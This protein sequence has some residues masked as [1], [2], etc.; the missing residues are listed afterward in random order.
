M[1][2]QHEP[3]AIHLDQQIVLLQTRLSCR[4]VAGHISDEQPF[5]GLQTQ[6]RRQRV[7]RFLRGQTQPRH[8]FDGAA[9]GVCVATHGL[10]DD[11]LLFGA[12]LIGFN[13]FRV[14]GYL[15]PDNDAPFLLGDRRIIIR[16]VGLDND[17][18]FNPRAGFIDFSH[19]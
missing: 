17:A 18:L 2:G 9:L 4:A 15:A 14:A 12:G 7:R 13:V 8:F 19:G 6:L 3:L 11:L 1:P 5:A 10:D 16:R